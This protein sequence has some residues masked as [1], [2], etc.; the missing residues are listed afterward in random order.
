MFSYVHV[1]IY[2]WFR[3]LGFYVHVSLSLYIFYVLSSATAVTVHQQN[4]ATS[5]PVISIGV[6]DLNEPTW[7][8]VNWAK[9]SPLRPLIGWWYSIE[10][11]GTVQ[12]WPSREI[13]PGTTCCPRLRW[14]SVGNWL[15]CQRNI[16]YIALSYVAVWHVNHF[17]TFFSW[18]MAWLYTKSV[19]TTK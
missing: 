12:Q 14:K 13:E 18:H 19:E 7:P 17:P 9:S 3:V 15:K 2:F 5:S 6:L 1:S 4:Q 10:K 16:A 8:G 11:W